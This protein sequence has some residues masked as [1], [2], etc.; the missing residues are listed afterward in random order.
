MDWQ[1]ESGSRTTVFISATTSDLHECRRIVSDILLQAGIFPVVQDYFGPD[2]R[3]IEKMINDKI[4]AVDAVICLVGHAYGAAPEST[5]NAKRSYTQI[6]Y[7]VA[8]RYEK[9]IYCFVATDEYALNNPVNET[10]SL[11]IKQEAHRKDILSR[12]D[13]Y[14]TFSSSSDLKNQIHDLVRPILEHSGRRSIKFI[15]PQKE[16]RCF[17]GRTNE[18][19]ELNNS[20][21]KRSPS[22][23]VLLGMGGQG[24]STL[25]AQ[26]IKSRDSLPFA[27]GI[28]VSAERGF[29]FSEFLDCTLESF[30]GSRFNKTE[31]PRLDTRIRNLILLLQAKPLLIVIDA[32][33]RWLT[34]WVND[35][36]LDGL[37][38]MSQ[39]QGAD[40]GIDDFLKEITALDSGSHIII[41]S[42]VLPAALDAVDCAIVPILPKDSIEHGLPALS[43]DAAVELL[44]SLGVIAP[45]EKLREVAKSLVN[46]PLALTGF[47]VVAE[48]R[49]V[50]WESL[51]SGKSKDPSRVFHQLL[52]ETR[53]HLPDRLR[54]E[55][56]LKIVSCIPEGVTLEA[57]EWLIKSKELYKKSLTSDL[58][59]QVLILADWNLLIWDSNAQSVRLHA[60]VA[61]YFSELLELS[62]QYTVHNF[63]SKWYELKANETG[64]TPEGASNRIFAVRHAI[65]SKDSQRAMR[66]IFESDAGNPNLVDWLS[67]NGH[68]WECSEL[69][70]ATQHIADDMDKITCILTRTRILHELELSQLI[71][72]ELKNAEELIL[73]NNIKTAKFLQLALAQCYGLQGLIHVE[74][75][76]ASD[77]LPLL[78]KSVALFESIGRTTNDYIVDLVKTLANRGLASW[79]CGDWDDANKDYSRCIEL[80][81]KTNQSN[82]ADLEIMIQE[83]QARQA[84][85]SIDQGNPTQAILLLENVV[86]ALKTAQTNATGR[87][88]KNYFVPFVSLATA[89]NLVK[90][91]AEAL[92]ILEDVI[93]PLEEMAKQGRW[94]YNSIL[95]Q[96]YVNE[97]NA[98]LL[99]ERIEEAKKFSDRASRIYEEL[100][101][102]GANQFSGQLANALFRRSEANIRSKEDGSDG[103]NDLQRALELSGEWL[104]NWFGES[105]IEN[106]FLKN[107]LRAISFLPQEN[108]QQQ[109]EVLGHIQ[110]LIGR[111]ENSPRQSEAMLVAKKIVSFHWATL[112]SAANNADIQWPE[113]CPFGS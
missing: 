31:M 74:T 40:D 62:E 92:K 61:E 67:F 48:K 27:A 52:D 9:P 57:L 64:M 78:D 87:P 98:L 111:L 56:L 86:H 70:Q 3:T 2:H 25:V 45:I 112:K 34:G 53:K 60:L 94:E 43:E 11:Q 75:S 108:V 4:L 12:P 96:A 59:A 106:V 68:L 84:A 89:Y 22:V 51:L 80:L 82:R 72:P 19:A 49:G 8:Y 1:V 24:K 93:L 41:T 13:K 113:M 73:T 20:L 54:S 71:L 110:Y 100:L 79:C 58:L 55:L 69:L 6:E 104:R 101:E 17:V 81:E 109:R 37:Y 97:T 42:R 77:G 105:N 102:K 33:E 18:I 47:A 46:H 21:N 38:D 36:H 7:D 16:P 32:M 10:D 85:I 99:L 30:M 91:P 35:R 66:L 88:T 65:S 14:Q 76:K 95:A 39:R 15:H 63:I 83:L 23:I 44:T 107:A 50:K 5:G 103:L 90:T 28:W 26:S 29:T